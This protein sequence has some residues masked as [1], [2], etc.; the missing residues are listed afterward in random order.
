MTRPDHIV[1]QGD[2]GQRI[3]AVLTDADG[4]AINLTGATIRF[5]MAE[6]TGGTAV[7]T[8]AAINVQVT[9]SGATGAVA[10]EWLATNTATAGAYLGEWEAIFAT[11]AT[12][13]YPNTDYVNILISEQ[14]AG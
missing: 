3:E 9:E 7:L 12:V 6:I 2:S 13:T 11:G 14:L 5:K 8:T 1:R 10:Y 4:V